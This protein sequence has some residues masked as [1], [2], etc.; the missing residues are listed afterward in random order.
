MARPVQGATLPKAMRRNLYAGQH[1]AADDHFHRA[2]LAVIA[3]QAQR[4]TMRASGEGT[5]GHEYR[6]G[7][8]DDDGSSRR[9]QP[10]AEAAITGF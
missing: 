3:S 4:A 5:A 10:P 7:L 2:L 9:S 1:R 6:M 8:A